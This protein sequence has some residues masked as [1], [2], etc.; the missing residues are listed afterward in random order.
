[1]VMNCRFYI[2][3]SCCK[4]RRL[5]I[6]SLAS[7]RARSMLL[8]ETKCTKSCKKG[9]GSTVNTS[10]RSSR[11]SMASLTFGFS[12]TVFEVPQTWSC[13]ANLPQRIQYF[14]QSGTYLSQMVLNSAKYL[15]DASCLLHRIMTSLQESDRDVASPVLCSAIQKDP[16]RQLGKF[17]LGVTVSL[18]VFLGLLGLWSPPTSDIQVYITI[19]LCSVIE[20]K[21]TC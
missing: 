12:L 7:L 10:T 5:Q 20:G 21:V 8:F 16:T 11:Q 18:I 19:L 17:T 3:Y 6:F 9:P 4:A 14:C 1:M 13:W 15:F 2:A